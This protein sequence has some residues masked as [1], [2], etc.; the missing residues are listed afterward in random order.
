MNK[1]LQFLFAVLFSTAGFYLAFKG[2]DFSALIFH[3]SSVN[4]WGVIISI[5]LLIIS[6]FIR[7]LRW[8]LFI[9][10][11]DFVP[12]NQVFSATMIGYF[13]NGVLAFRLGEVL[14]SYSIS[15]NT[16][17]ATMQAFGTVIIERTLD[18]ISVIIIFIFIVP[19]FPFHDQYI[20]YS[21]IA[22][23]G[24]SLVSIFF[25]Y[26]IIRHNGIEYSKELGI[27]DSQYGRKIFVLLERLFDGLSIL[28]RM[29]NTN[30]IILLSMIL[31]SIYYIQTI[32]L[33]NACGIT[34]NI[35]EVGIL[36][37]V[38]SIIIGLPALP[39]SIGTYDAGIKYSLI[40]IFNIANDSALN[41]AIVSHAVSY[42]PLTIIGFLYFLIG[43]YN[44]S[45]LKKIE[46]NK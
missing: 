20:K 36:L 23:I 10:Y 12:F 33:V 21:A 14:K 44:L 24:I 25:L 8:Q 28:H 22:V 5:L 13:G 16:N 38:G 42:F 26:F 7:A 27:F 11:F 31:W 41:Y 35:I 1:N 37:V 29:K 4:I 32:I 2:E 19:W 18:V 34:L 46:L 9:R 39:G 43:N 6:C 30:S 15:Q 17:I 3:L 40:V 45:D